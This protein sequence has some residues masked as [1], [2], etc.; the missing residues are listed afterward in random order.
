[1]PQKKVWA[2]APAMSKPSR[3]SNPDNSTG[4]PRT[5]FVTTRTAGGRSLFQTERMT[6]L[7][8]D[9][10]RSTMRSGAVTVHDFVLMPNHVHILLTVSWRDKP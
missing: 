3:P 4:S 1:M 8:V 6:D 2:L 9:I 10:L 5:F 7:F